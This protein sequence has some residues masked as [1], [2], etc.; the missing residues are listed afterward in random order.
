[1]I[2]QIL[3][4]RVETAPLRGRAVQLLHEHR[5]PT[6]GSGAGIHAVTARG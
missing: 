1:M 4:D 5:R 2:G 3:E 6:G